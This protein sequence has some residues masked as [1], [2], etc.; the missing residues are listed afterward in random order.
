MII[1][2]TNEVIPLPLYYFY[3]SYYCPGKDL[4]PESN[5]VDVAVFSGRGFCTKSTK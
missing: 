1:P 3:L 2:V 4:C 5:L